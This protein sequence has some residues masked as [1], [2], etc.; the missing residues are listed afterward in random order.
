VGY[1]A[2]K[3]WTQYPTPSAAQGTSTLLSNSPLGSNAS[4]PYA[5]SSVYQAPSGAWVFAAGANAWTLALDSYANSNFV[6]PRIQKTTA[7]V[8]NQFLN[9]PVNF[10]IAA[11]PSSQSVTQGGSTTYSV[12]VSPIGGFSNPVTLSVSGLPSGANSTFSPNPTTA[13]STLSVTTSTTTPIGTYTLTITGVSG[14]LT[15]TTTVTLAETLP[16][17]KFDNSA[18]SGFQWSVTS[19][20]TPGFMVGTGANRAAMIMVVMTANSAKGMSASLGGV[21]GTLCPGT[22]SGTT[23]TL[24]TLIFQVTSPP[25]GLQTATVSWTNSLNADIG[26]IT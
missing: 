20:T 26:V 13:S 4:Q 12:T 10:S 5:N 1:E 2:D 3:M 22:D 19:I 18:S 24:R 11:S 25:A 8:L 21:A 7:N 16:G 6:D 9:P 14:S 23:A 15:R 17:V